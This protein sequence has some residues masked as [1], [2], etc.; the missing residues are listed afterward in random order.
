[1]LLMEGK[2]VIVLGHSLVEIKNKHPNM[3]QYTGK[4]L[5]VVYMFA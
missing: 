4:T 1:M 5:T 3:Q 2:R